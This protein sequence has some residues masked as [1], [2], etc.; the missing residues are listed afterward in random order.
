VETKS[1]IGATAKKTVSLRQKHV[2]AIELNTCE[3]QSAVTAKKTVTAHSGFASPVSGIRLN[4][5]LSHAWNSLH[6]P[7]A[8]LLIVFEEIKVTHR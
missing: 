7:R 6:A 5:A 1:T 3:Q 8:P 2:R 4:D